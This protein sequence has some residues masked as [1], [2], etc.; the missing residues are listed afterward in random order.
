MEIMSH[1]TIII[2][3]I[4]NH[5]RAWSLTKAIKSQKMS[6]V[7]F[8]PS[9][10]VSSPS[11]RFPNTLRSLVEDSLAFLPSLA[12]GARR[13]K[14][15]DCNAAPPLLCVFLNTAAAV[16]ARLPT[17]THA[18]IPLLLLCIPTHGKSERAVADEDEPAIDKMTQILASINTLGLEMNRQVI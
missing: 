18:A 8:E 9:L 16:G 4:F 7:I 17:K 12:S 15:G 5:S 10:N 6:Y 14:T 2:I 11:C 13:S 3:C 1:P